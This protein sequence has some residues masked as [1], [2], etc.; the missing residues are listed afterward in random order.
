MRQR[1]VRLRGH[2]LI[3]CYDAAHRSDQAGRFLGRQLRVRRGAHVA[4]V[5]CGT[6]V[7]AF[8]AA[9]LGAARVWA[10][11]VVPAAVTLADEGAR[12]NE[13][14]H[15]VTARVAALLDGVPHEESLDLVLAVMPQRP[16][17][18]DFSARYA[19]GPDGADL[20]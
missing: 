11:D 15:V 4:E 20:L 18:R 3:E 2:A 8:L 19:G 14:D 1:I 10:T 12:R 13:L 17:P 16:A 6:G 9:R 5:G 7:L